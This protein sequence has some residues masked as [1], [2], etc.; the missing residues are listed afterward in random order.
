VCVEDGH[1]D[2]LTLRL[3]PPGVR[4]IIARLQAA[5]REIEPNPLAPIEDTALIESTD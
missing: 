4:K 2:F 1:F 3:F 5:A